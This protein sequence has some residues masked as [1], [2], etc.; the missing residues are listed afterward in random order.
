MFYEINSTLTQV[1]LSELN[2]EKLTVGYMTSEELAKY[3][4]SLGFDDETI[5]A[6]QK[7]N[8]LF[9]TGVD[10]HSDYTFAEIRVVNRNG[11]EDFVSLYVK[12]NFLL[13]VDIQDEDDSTIGAF[14][15]ALKRFPC[16][17][18]KAERVI[19]GFF[20]QLLFEGNIVSEEIRNTLTEMEES[21]VNEKVEDNL[22]L[23]LF[24]IKKRILKYHNY[25]GQI[26]DIIETLED[27]DNE[28]ID[29]ENLFYLSNLLNKVTRISADIDTLDNMADHIQ[30]AYAMSLDL[31]MNNLMKLF[32][33]ITVIFLP[34]TIIVG[35]YGMNFEGMPELTWK[36]GYFYVTILSVAVILLLLF[37]GKKKKW[38]D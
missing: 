18:I 23:E 30:E 25:Y 13:I 12:K 10:V 34:L 14:M 28:V 5:N 16:S 22:N 6:S 20:E 27:N 8:P 2:S 7:A 4:K 11:A 1:E 19:Y 35:W 38:F 21:I 32:T 3:G 36:Y 31:K 33:I 26:S 17:K 24:T 15:K 9:R 37:I 29:G